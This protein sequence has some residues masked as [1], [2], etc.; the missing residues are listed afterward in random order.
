MLNFSREATFFLLPV[1]LPALELVLLKEVSILLCCFLFF[2]IY[3]IA[4][5]LVAELVSITCMHILS[6]P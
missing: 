2:L 3:F 1:I 5:N 6:L 4:K